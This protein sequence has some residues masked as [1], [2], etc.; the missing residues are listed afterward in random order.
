MFRG[1][2]GGLY[3]GWALGYIVVTSCYAGSYVFYGK[4]RD[5]G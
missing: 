1:V 4:F 3:Q 2:Y 5:Y